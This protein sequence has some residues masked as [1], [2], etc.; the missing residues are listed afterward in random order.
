MDTIGEMKFVLYK[1]VSFIQ[2]FLN[3]VP[4][5]FG[6]Y[7]LMSFIQWVSSIQGCP[8][9]GVSLYYRPSTTK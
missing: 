4:I 8:L 1:K 2:G 6:T 3:A 5:H 9:R 7:R